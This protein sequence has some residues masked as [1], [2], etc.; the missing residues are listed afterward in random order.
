LI[1]GGALRGFRHPLGAILLT[2]LGL[3]SA[4]L[5]A[6]PYVGLIAMFTGVGLLIAWFRRRHARRAAIAGC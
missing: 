5:N 2:I 3:A 4:C 1:R 6:L